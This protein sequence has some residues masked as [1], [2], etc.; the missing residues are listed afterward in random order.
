MSSKIEAEKLKIK[1]QT[2][3]SASQMVKQGDIISIRGRG[4]LEVAEVRVT[5]K[6]GRTVVL[7]NRYL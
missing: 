5:T 2:G 3:K 4:R 6:K 1:W 7:L